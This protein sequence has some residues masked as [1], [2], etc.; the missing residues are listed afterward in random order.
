MASF[1]INGE[2][3]DVDANPNTPLLWVVREHL[4]L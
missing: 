3:V 1:T 4:Q 2:Q